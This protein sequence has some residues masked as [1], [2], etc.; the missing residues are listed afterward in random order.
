MIF[1][2]KW[3]VLLAKH[4]II[5]KWRHI[6]NY[7]IMPQTYPPPNSLFCRQ[8]RMQFL[9]AGCARKIKESA[10]KCASVLVKPRAWM[11][12][13]NA[14]FCWASPL[15]FANIFSKSSSNQQ[16]S[17]FRKFWHTEKQALIFQGLDG[18]VMFF[19]SKTRSRHS[20][21]LTLSHCSMKY[22]H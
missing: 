10:Q 7:I 3:N 15:E 1:L 17:F 20:S 11:S 16:D 4:I 18:V 19:Q 13:W 8:R 12:V 9:R 21:A 14:W 2:L 22:K 5:N 6:Y